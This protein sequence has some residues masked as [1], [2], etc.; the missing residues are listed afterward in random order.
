MSFLKHPRAR[1][2]D[3]LNRFTHIKTIGFHGA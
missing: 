3:G 2:I 1:Y